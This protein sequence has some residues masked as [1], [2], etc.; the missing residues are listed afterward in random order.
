M[1]VCGAVF[2]CAR[3][4]K[5]QLRVRTIYKSKLF[6]YDDD[7]HLAVFWV[8]CEA[9]TYVR[10]LCV[11]LGLLLGV[12][13]HMQVCHS[14]ISASLLEFK[15][16]WHCRVISMASCLPCNCLNHMLQ[17]VVDAVAGILGLL[18][19]VGVCW[20][21]YAAAA[22]HCGYASALVTDKCGMQE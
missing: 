15:H 19:P 14:R 7:H 13:G 22:F 3:A 6:E 18:T 4:V 16:A 20:H 12:G 11:H 17:A 8:S 9:G 10:T 21:Q 1:F 5:R 2:V